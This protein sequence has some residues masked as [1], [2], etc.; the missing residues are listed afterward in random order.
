VLKHGHQWP[1]AVL[2]AFYKLPNQPDPETIETII[3]MD[4][5]IIQQASADPAASRLRLGVIAILARSGDPES[6]DYLRRLWQQEP[7]R[8]ND[9]VIGLAQ[10]PGD[11]NW[12]YLVS[13]LSVLDDLTGIEVMEKL[14]GVS[15][16]PRNS[17]HFRDVITLGYRLRSEGA[18]V[19]VRLLE[20]WSGEKLE[21]ADGQWESALNTWRDWFHQKWPDQDEIV[22]QQNS[23]KVG[24]YSVAQLLVSFENTG[25]G[26]LHRGREV[27]T[28]AQC[29]NCHQFAN[30]G[31]GMGP[32]LTSLAQ[33]FSLREAIESTIDPSH[34]IPDRYASKK[35]VTVDGNQFSG[36]AVLQADGSYFVLQSDGKRIRVA[37]EEIEDVKESATSAMPEGLLDSLSISEINDLFTFLM[38]PKQQQTVGSSQDN[39]SVSQAETAPI[40]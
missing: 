12:A 26:D 31:Q 6:M 15:R 21:L 33:R 40:R 24:R 19:A 34:V 14:T 22:S 1:N 8:R 11:E 32:D 29:A 28:K 2:A 10:Q 37:A 7:E 36:M 39:N 27:F 4:Q 23:E 20:H 3:Q 13:S 30:H 18:Q 16:R 9:I 38:P 5:A 25:A 17:K 35:I